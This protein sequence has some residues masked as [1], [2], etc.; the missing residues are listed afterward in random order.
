MKFISVDFLQKK[1]C[2]ATAT[3]ISSSASIAADN[4]AYLTSAILVVTGSIS[5]KLDKC[6]KSVLP[7]KNVFELT[8]AT[9]VQERFDVKLQFN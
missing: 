6:E 2:F 9:E 4:L 7:N 5:C 3:I 8:S 1:L